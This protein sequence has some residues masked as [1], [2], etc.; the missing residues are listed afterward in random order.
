MLTNWNNKKSEHKIRKCKMQRYDVNVGSSFQA[1][2][3]I[4]NKCIPSSAQK[5]EGERENHANQL[6][7]AEDEKFLQNTL[8]VDILI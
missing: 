8:L 6:G 4:Q 2:Q 7:V 3:T 5:E 1:V